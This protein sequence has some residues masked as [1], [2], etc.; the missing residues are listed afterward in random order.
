VNPVI[1][2]IER[3]GMEMAD[4]IITVSNFTRGTV[5]E[6]Y[7][8]PPEKITTVYNAVEPQASSRKSPFKKGVNEKV[9]TFLGRITMQKARIFY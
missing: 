4:K 9:V 7:G 5:I 2:S 6:K 1:Y 8:I 3:E